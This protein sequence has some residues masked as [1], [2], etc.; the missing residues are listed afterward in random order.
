MDKKIDK[1][2][3]D[4]IENDIE[5]SR[6]EIIVDGIIKSIKSWIGESPES[7]D[8]A[9]SLIAEHGVEDFVEWFINSKYV[10]EIDDFSEICYISENKSGLI[11]IIVDQLVNF[12]VDQLVD[13]LVD[14]ESGGDDGEDELQTALE[15]INSF[16]KSE[17]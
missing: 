8:K 15:F 14:E 16:D 11:D 3:K 17:E 9:T 6:D 7:K 2:S 5:S 13:E 10:N 4:R 12:D 1:F